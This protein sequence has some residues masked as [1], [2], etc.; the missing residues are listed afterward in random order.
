ME[1]P[2]A[3]QLCERIGALKESPQ[4]TESKRSSSASEGDV[5]EQLQRERHQQE[6]SQGEIRRLRDEVRQKEMLVN[7]VFQNAKQ[8]QMLTVEREVQNER[9]RI[10]QL[11]QQLAQNQAQMRQLH[12]QVRIE[13][14]RATQSQTE[15]TQAREQISRTEGQLHQHIQDLEQRHEQE[16]QRAADDS[17][18]KAARIQELERRLEQSEV[19][20]LG[21]RVTGLQLLPQGDSW[22]IPRREVRITEQIGYGAAG[23]VSKGRYQGQEVAVKQI[24]REILREK[25]IMDEFKREVGIM[26]TIQ[27]PNLVRFIAAVFDERV[28]QLRE[29]PLLV[30]EL[31]HT[32][33]RNAYKALVPARVCQSF[34]I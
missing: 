2:S 1:R 26:A 27:H 30:L 16:Q 14:Q 28:E 21:S 25:H 18:V 29:T 24:H 33:L 31:L 19:E 20:T 15:L 32:N 23:L 12:Q 11:E 4:Y 10:A 17:R 3:H 6:Q 13:Q 22:N 5:Q 7:E 8:K 34:V 9:R